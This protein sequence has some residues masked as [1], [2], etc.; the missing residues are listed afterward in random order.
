M[1][2]ACDS[3]GASYEA[4]RKNSR[5]CSGTCRV[6]ASRGAV[7]PAVRASVSSLPPPVVEP[8]E[9]SLGLVVAVRQ[10]LEDAHR[11]ETSLG[12]ASLALAVRLE[13]KGD[14]GAAVASLNR[15][16]RATL[17]EAV[18]G[19]HVAKSTLQSYRDELAARRRA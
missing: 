11:L 3:C 19:A 9:S 12:Q 2:R 6:R 13:S 18:K 4:K 16:L 15:E 8:E 1:Q 10:E 14:T 7:T 17:A 5:F